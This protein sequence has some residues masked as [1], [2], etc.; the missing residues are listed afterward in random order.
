[1]YLIM[2]SLLSLENVNVIHRPV[3]FSEILLPKLHANANLVVFAWFCITD[4]NEFWASV[5]KLIYLN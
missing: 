3:M 1:M 2:S 5:V 4:L